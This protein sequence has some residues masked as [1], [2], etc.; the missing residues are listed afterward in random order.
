MRLR[1]RYGV[2]LEQDVI[3][4]AASGMA[5]VSAWVARKGAADNEPRARY[6]DLPS[7]VLGRRGDFMSG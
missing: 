4:L 2:S 5:T 7:G 6:D 1:A 3:A